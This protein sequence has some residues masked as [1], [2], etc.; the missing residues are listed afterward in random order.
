M[1]ST[2]SIS[3]GLGDMLLVLQLVIIHINTSYTSF[4]ILGPGWVGTDAKKLKVLLIKAPLWGFEL[5]HVKL[6]Y[7]NLNGVV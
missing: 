7:K 6:I 2:R 3:P 5:V 1:S 4:Y